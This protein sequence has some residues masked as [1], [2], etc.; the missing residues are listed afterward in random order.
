MGNLI[1]SE[2]GLRRVFAGLT[3]Q[4][5]ISDLGIADPPLIDYLVD[6]LVRFVK[7]DSI[8]RVRDNTGRRLN[9]VTGMLLE[10]EQRQ[11]RPQRELLRHIGDFTLFWTG[12]FPEALKR[13]QRPGSRDALIDY[14][15]QGK[16]SY[17]RASQ[18]DDRRCRCQN[19]VLHRLS[20]EFELCAAGLNRVRRQWDAL[21]ENDRS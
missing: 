21:S 17:F 12:V 3:E 11:A 6:L 18:F 1:G 8:Y 10:A 13:L 15:D 2:N 20:E 4:T 16:Q 9:D 5:F 7:T 14:L 19:P